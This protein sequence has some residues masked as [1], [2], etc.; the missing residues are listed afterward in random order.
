MILE[1]LLDHKGISPCAAVS[2]EWRV[3]IEKR[4]FSH[5]KLH[6]TCLVFLAQLAEE[7]TA[8]IDHIWLNI[9]LQRYTCRDCR[10]EEPDTWSRSNDKIVAA[11]VAR[12]F[13]IL[14][15]WNWKKANFERHLTLELNAYSPSDSEHW[16]RD[17]YFGAPGEDKFEVLPKGE[18]AHDPRHRW[19][20]DRRAKAPPDGALRRPFEP[21]FINFK[22]D[23]Q[24]L[25]LVHVVTKF[26]LRRQCRRHFDPLALSHLWSKLP[27]LDEICYEPWQ[28]SLLYTYHC[29]EKSKHPIQLRLR[30]R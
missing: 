21:S 16:F 8:Q 30:D 20:H 23:A 18:I 29:W 10:S 4:M 6:P 3:V 5:L 27:R 24:E 7:Q 11:S 28:S 13:S 22:K 17:C 25:P 15:N 26:I 1:R 12:L 2:K 14:A 19:C 9:E